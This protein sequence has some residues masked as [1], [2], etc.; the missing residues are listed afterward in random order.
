MIKESVIKFDE[1]ITEAQVQ[2]LN[3]I[4]R[5]KLVGKPLEKITGQ[6]EDYIMAEIKTGVKIIKKIIKEIN[7][8][9]EE[10]FKFIEKFKK[11]IRSDGQVSIKFTISSRRP[12]SKINSIFRDIG[13]IDS[14]EIL[15]VHEWQIT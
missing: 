8:I 13:N 1:N 4:F 9:I 10:N 5:N 12:I 7:K 3:E 11:K 14:L 2:D 6:F 15:E